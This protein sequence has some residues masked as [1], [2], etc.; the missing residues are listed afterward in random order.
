MEELVTV[1]IP[2]YNRADI[3]EKCIESVRN[4]TYRNLEIIVWDDGSEDETEEVVRGIRDERIRYYKGPNGGAAHARNMGI[5]Q[6]RGEYIAF[7]DS[8]DFCRPHRIE[9]QL[10]FLKETNSDMVYAQLERHNYENPDIVHVYPDDGGIGETNEETYRNFLTRGS[11]W[12]VVIFC[13]AEC[14][15]KCK[16][17]ETLPAMED[18]EWSLRVAKNFKVNWKEEVIVDSY[19]SQNSISRSSYNK[20]LTLKMMFG[21]Y[22]EDIKKYK[23]Q[24]IWDWL[25][26]FY[27]YNDYPET[28][29][30]YGVKSIRYGWKTGSVKEIILGIS[31]IIYVR[32]LQKLVR[33]IRRK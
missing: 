30:D 14:C 21:T 6:A 4:Q 2:T 5:E 10:Q 28:H 17:D 33:K 29:V 23:I 16:F 7:H 1:I 13:R 27:K 3:I 24:A 31:Y 25:M 8:D 19:V 12:T 20:Y 18:W 15:R 9:H 26:A 11:V 22:A 32:P